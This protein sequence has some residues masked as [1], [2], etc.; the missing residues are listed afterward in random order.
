[1]THTNKMATTVYRIVS[2]FYFFADKE[3]DLLFNKENNLIHLVFQS[4]TRKLL[5]I[6][7]YIHHMNI[8]NYLNYSLVP[9]VSVVGT[10]HWTDVWNFSFQS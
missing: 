4:C 10:R 3:L 8:G 1:M 5:Y 2:I 9:S 7:D 6:C